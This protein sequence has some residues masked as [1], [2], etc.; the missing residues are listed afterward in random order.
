MKRFWHA[1]LLAGLWMAAGAVT[2][3]KAQDSLDA[4]V[5]QY[6]EVLVYR[7]LALH[8]A[9]DRLGAVAEWERYLAIAP[10]GAD[11]ASVRALAEDAFFAEFPMALLYR[12]IVLSQRG[13]HAGAIKAWQRYLGPGLSTRE[14]QHVHGLIAWARE[15]QRRTLAA[16]SRR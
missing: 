6:P 5:R 3:A 10:R 13:D 7:G 12:G 1:T 8:A 9:G 2:P 4:F 16:G 14:W 15:E 11:T